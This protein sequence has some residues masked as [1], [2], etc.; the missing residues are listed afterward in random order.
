MAQAV[1]QLSSKYKALSSNPSITNHQKEREKGKERR[2]EGSEGEKE[3]GKEGG[4]TK[5]NKMRT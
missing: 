4:E 1:E 3:G 5:E 2:K